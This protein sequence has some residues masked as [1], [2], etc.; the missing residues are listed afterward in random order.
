MTPTRLS[1]RN[2]CKQ[3]RTNIRTLIILPTTIIKNQTNH[4]FYRLW[5][6][7]S[8][9][10]V[11]DGGLLQQINC[12]EKNTND[13]AVKMTSVLVL[14]SNPNKERW[15]CVPSDYSVWKPKATSNFFLSAHTPLLLDWHS[16]GFALNLSPSMKR[17]PNVHNILHA[18]GGPVSPYWCPLGA[19]VVSPNCVHATRWLAPKTTL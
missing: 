3:A 12:W 2:K 14:F 7:V 4:A 5:W 18:R 6:P 19:H 17:Q 1:S 8:L 10:L 16:L 11:R 15:P 13:D 9:S